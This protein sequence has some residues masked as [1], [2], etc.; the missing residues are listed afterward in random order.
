MVRETHES[1]LERDERTVVVVSDWG[2][3]VDTKGRVIVNDFLTLIFL[4]VPA[5]AV[6]PC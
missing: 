2:N 4:L 5:T 6:C 1:T 3:S